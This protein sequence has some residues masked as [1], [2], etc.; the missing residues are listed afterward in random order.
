MDADFNANGGDF[1]TLAGQGPV[2]GRLK[3]FD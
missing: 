1:E 3:T 2:L